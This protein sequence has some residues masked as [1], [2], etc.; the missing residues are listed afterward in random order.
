MMNTITMDVL[1]KRVSFNATPDVDELLKGLTG[2]QLVRP[3]CVFSRN[4]V[5]ICVEQTLKAF[6]NG[7]NIARAPEIEFLIRI[8][9]E[10]Q[11]KAALKA[12][13]VKKEAVFVSWN[14]DAEK[15]YASLK[16][17]FPLKE[18]QL[19]ART[20]DEVKQAIERSATFFIR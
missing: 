6:R 7:S 20:D 17:S 3:E 2:A 14:E 8:T 19:E 15:Q 11:I 18:R 1:V 16:R 13:S 5:I 9:G 4:H 10:R 12:A